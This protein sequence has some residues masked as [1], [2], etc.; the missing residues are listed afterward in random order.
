MIQEAGRETEKT[1][2]VKRLDLSFAIAIFYS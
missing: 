2:T 1:G